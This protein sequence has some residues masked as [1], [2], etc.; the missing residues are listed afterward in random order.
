[1][2]KIIAFLLLLTL[3]FADNVEKPEEVD[4]NMEHPGTKDLDKD[5]KILK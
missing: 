5:S 4:P 2:K 3:A 1:M